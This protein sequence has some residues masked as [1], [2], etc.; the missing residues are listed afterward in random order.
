MFFV[1]TFNMVLEQDIEQTLDNTTSDRNQT[2]ETVVGFSV[3]IDAQ[4][5]AAKDEWF[6]HLQT[7][8]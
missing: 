3:S 5:S 8:P 7:M 2:E 1:S 6:N 4:I